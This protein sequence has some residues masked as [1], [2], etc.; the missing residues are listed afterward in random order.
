[1]QP[2]LIAWLCGVSSPAFVEYRGLQMVFANVMPALIETAK[3][4]AS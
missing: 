1:M 3:S 4:Y 2:A